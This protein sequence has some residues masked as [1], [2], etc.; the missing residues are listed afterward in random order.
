MCS[1]M[2][3]CGATLHVC[4]LSACAQ[5]F[6][7]YRVVADIGGGYGRLLMDI[8]DTYPGWCFV[9]VWFVIACIASLST[10]PPSLKVLC[11]KTTLKY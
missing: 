8:M 4:C 9:Y 10:P 5:D 11:S 3:L 7:S 2:P 1:T 6:S